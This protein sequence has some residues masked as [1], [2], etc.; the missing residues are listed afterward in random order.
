MA[1]HVQLLTMRDVGKLY[2][3]V[4][5]NLVVLLIGCWLVSAATNLF[6]QVFNILKLRNTEKAIHSSVVKRKTASDFM[7]TPYVLSLHDTRHTHQVKHRI[8]RILRMQVCI[9]H[10]LWAN[11][12]L[13]H[14][15]MQAGMSRDLVPERPRALSLHTTLLSLHTTLL[16]AARIARHR[17]RRPCHL[18]IQ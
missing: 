3:G 14:L 4:T 8:L 9:E 2:I 17:Y 16:R 12:Q 5:F 13:M 15:H 6:G 11:T 7:F 10:Q 18:G 1:C